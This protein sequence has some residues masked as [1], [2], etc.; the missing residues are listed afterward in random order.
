MW[1]EESLE[2]D[3]KFVCNGDLWEETQYHLGMRRG[4]KEGEKKRDYC[5]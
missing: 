1:E 5:D 2:L 3:E 4:K